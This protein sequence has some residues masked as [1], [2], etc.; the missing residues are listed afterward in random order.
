MIINCNPK[1]N[2]DTQTTT[3][4]SYYE[5]LTG[6]SL[7]YTD[8]DLDSSE[9][10][11]F[12]PAYADYLRKIKSMA[13]S[14]DANEVVTVT[15]LCPYLEAHLECPFG[16]SCDFIHALMCDQCQQFV[17]RPDDPEQQESHRI[18]CMKE[19]EAEM[20]EAF[21]VAASR[22]R[23]CGICMEVVWEKE[24]AS[25]RRFGIL[26]C[27]NHIFCLSCIRKW[28][29]SKAY[30]NKVVKAC[31]ECRVKSDFVT[32]S[33]FWFENHDSKKKIIDE[34]KSKLG[35]FWA[36]YLSTSIY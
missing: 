15:P 30:E 2:Q 6:K 7:D 24:P 11:M 23:L 25:E 13:P 17:L 1:P 4:S 27:C 33:R 5:A 8:L 12:E 36:T 29:A 32:P 26:E 18:E 9:I 21:A 34:Y 14:S 31:P 10:N 16:D 35:Y 28:R 3:P 22:E 19:I 20:E